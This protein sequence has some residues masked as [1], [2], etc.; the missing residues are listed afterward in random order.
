MIG[1][2]QW[3]FGVEWDNNGKRKIKS[4]RDLTQARVFYDSRRTN[5]SNPVL[6]RWAPEPL[7]KRILLARLEWLGFSLLL[8]PSLL[9]L[10]LSFELLNHWSKL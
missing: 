2:K 7:W 3:N 9:F 1:F 10:F 6:F 5:F 8:W 4:F